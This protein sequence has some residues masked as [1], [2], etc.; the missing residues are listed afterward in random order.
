MRNRSQLTRKVTLLGQSRER[1]R[2]VERL[3]DQ[4]ASGCRHVVSNAHAVPS[5][6]DGRALSVFRLC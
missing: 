2:D 5:V 6:C 4:C 3:D 1:K